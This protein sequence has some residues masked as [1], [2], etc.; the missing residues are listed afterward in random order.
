MCDTNKNKNVQWEYIN[1]NITTNL[2]GQH[3]RLII[4]MKNI[5]ICQLF[6][7]T[8]MCHSSTS[9]FGIL[10]N[11]LGNIQLALFVVLSRVMD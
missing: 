5:N 8:Q 3:E 7:I 9:V 10:R 4:A 1:Q 6:P 2:L 11:T